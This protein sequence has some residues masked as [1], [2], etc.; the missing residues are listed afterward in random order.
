MVAVRDVMTAG[1]DCVRTDQTAA[2]AARLMADLSVG[3]L[4]ICGKDEKIK[5]VVTDRDLVTKVLAQG[6]DAGT[7]PAGDLNQDE[8]VTVGA[9]DSIDEAVQTVSDHH[10]RRLP[11]IDG[12]R[13][14]GMVTIDD[15]ARE[16]PQD[17]AGPVFKSLFASA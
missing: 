8:A 6:R 11:V 2:D 9:D 5:G 1:A 3:A 4:P 14:V 10:V 16:L 17:Q 12:T 13:L 7:F 15:L